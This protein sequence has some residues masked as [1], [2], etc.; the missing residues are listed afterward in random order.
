MEFDRISKFKGICCLCLMCVA[1]TACNSEG[2][3]GG[4]NEEE[5]PIFGLGVEETSFEYEEQ[6]PH[7]IVS[8]GYDTYEQKIVYADSSMSGQQFSVVADETGEVVYTGEFYSLSDAGDTACVG[9]FSEV[10]RSGSYLI[11]NK[12]CGYSYSF[13][14]SP[15]AY[16][17]FYEQ[18]YTRL[19]EMEC[20]NIEERCSRIS[21]AMLSSEI[22]EDSYIDWV[23]INQ[24]RNELEKYIKRT[25]LD[26]DGNIIE[27]N[28]A[29]D[30]E[31]WI[32]AGTLAQYGSLYMDLDEEKAVWSIQLA[33]NLYD[34]CIDV[35]SY[36]DG[37]YFALAYL[38][39]ATGDSKYRNILEKTKDWEDGKHSFLADMGYI[40]SVYPNDY[41]RCE[42]ILNGYLERAKNISI[43]H[44]SRVYFEEK[45]DS[46]KINDELDDLM[47][48]CIAD[49][50]LAGSEYKGI[51]RDYVR[52]VGGC[53]NASLDMITSP[54][55]HINS[56]ETM[57]KLI[58]VMGY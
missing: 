21:Y 16:E 5:T 1:L 37:R 9:D 15:N 7:L 55:Q 54:N 3:A 38:Y 44:N 42:K 10:V 47:V 13:D 14:I 6:K 18:A 45:T 29:D 25:Y 26:T 23:F 56:I 46:E 28:V 33:E 17:L 41:T 19:E 24:E 30:Y 52:F 22:Y 12:N 27:P 39:R 11:W 58:F 43:E 49:Y 20:N 2:V 34:S 31:K 57:A 35:N 36:N 53:N 50:A 40:M 32:V 4:A 51:R 8:S 48:L